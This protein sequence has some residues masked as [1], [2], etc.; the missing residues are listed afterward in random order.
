M[1]FSVDRVREHA[2]WRA[3]PYPIDANRAVL[4]IRTATSI[5]R[6]RRRSDKRLTFVLCSP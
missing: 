4:I 5:R 6:I 3:I 2:N 1:R